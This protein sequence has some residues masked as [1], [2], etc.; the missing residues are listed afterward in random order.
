MEPGQTVDWVNDQI[1]TARKPKSVDVKV[2]VTQST[3]PPNPPQ[4]TASPPKLKLDPVSGIEAQ[5]TVTNDSSVQQNNLT[6]FAVARK[7][8][9]IVAAGRGGMK[10]VK[11]HGSRDYHIFFIG[12]PKGAQVTVTVPPT[13][14]N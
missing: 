6:L 7:G 3:L 5:G 12:S 13:T 14:F 1:L 8:N 9:R 2:G 10:V 11:P 4:V